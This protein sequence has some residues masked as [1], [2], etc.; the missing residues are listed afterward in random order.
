MITAEFPMTIMENAIGP[1]SAPARK[2]P[3]PC[4]ECNQVTLFIK[5]YVN[6]QILLS[7]NMIH[8]YIFFMWLGLTKNKRRIHKERRKGK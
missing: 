6:R 3:P 2:K 7:L 8:Y 5:L 1:I 4:H